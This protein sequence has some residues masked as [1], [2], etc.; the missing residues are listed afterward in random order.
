MQPPQ[1]SG[2]DLP[3]NVLANETR[4]SSTDLEHQSSLSSRKRKL[5]DVWPV[6][7]HK[8]PKESSGTGTRTGSLSSISPRLERPKF[9][10]SSSTLAVPYRGTSKANANPSI[11]AAVVENTPKAPPKKGSFAEIMARGK[12]LQMSAPTVGAITHKP[13][14]K[15]ALSS[16]KEI[17]LQKKGMSKKQPPGSKE[18]LQQRTGPLSS[19]SKPALVP[20]NAKRA[21]VGE[22]KTPSTS[23][24]PA[25][26]G[27]ASSA[28]PQP[29]YKGTMKPPNPAE[30]K[31]S[32]ARSEDGRARSIT[33]FYP[34]PSVSKSRYRSYESDE[35]EDED[36]DEYDNEDDD[37]GVDHSSDD[38]EADFG[39]VEAEEESAIRIGKKEDE[40]ELKL[41]QKLKKEKEE[42]RK[43][44]ELLAKNAKKRSY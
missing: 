40:E 1:P 39:D 26:K 12:T 14:P 30:R 20:S 18:G 6:S 15:D 35:E 28:K 16:K 22:A 8:M 4:H 37:P 19:N 9:S 27:T 7:E 29:S 34:R 44:L 10:K 38:M 2:S 31:N 5:D 41:E 42:R 11:S 3:P 33:A 32:S 36:E 13:K 21:L 43:R 17:L 23:A 25:Y 24:S